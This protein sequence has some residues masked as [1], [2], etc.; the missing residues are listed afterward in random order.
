MIF[1]QCNP[2]DLK[3]KVYFIYIIY[4]PKYSSIDSFV[5][6]SKELP[7]CKYVD[8]KRMA[9]FLLAYFLHF[10]LKC[11]NEKYSYNIKPIWSEGDH[12]GFNWIFEIKYLCKDHDWKIFQK[13]EIFCEIWITYRAQDMI[14]ESVCNL[15]GHRYNDLI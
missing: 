9:Y 6:L 14:F 2:F 1:P 11:D 8:M 12:C 4:F 13:K 7:I 15:K 5:Y 3:T 10:E